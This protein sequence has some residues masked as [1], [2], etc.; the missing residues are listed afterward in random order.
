MLINLT[1]TEV[2]QPHDYKVLKVW[3]L[4]LQL[5]IPDSRQLTSF[6]SNSLQRTE[7]NSQLSKITP[8]SLVK[9]K[10]DGNGELILQIFFRKEETRGIKVL[11]VLFLTSFIRMSDFLPF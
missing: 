1:N 11:F 10:V 3:S 9:L 8:I 6:A 7:K 5:K 2:R 4:A